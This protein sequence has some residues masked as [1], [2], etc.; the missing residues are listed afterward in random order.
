VGTSQLTE[1]DQVLLRPRLTGVGFDVFYR[2]A[3]VAARL[4]GRGIEQGEVFVAR[5]H[6]TDAA[7]HRVAFARAVAGDVASPAR[8]A[9]WALRVLA[10]ETRNEARRAAA[11]FVAEAERSALVEPVTRAEAGLARA[12]GSG[13][14]VRVALAPD[15]HALTAAA[16]A[17]E[18]AFA[19]LVDRLAAPG[20]RTAMRSDADEVVAAARAAPQALL[21]RLRGEWPRLVRTVGDDAPLPLTADGGGTG[22]AVTVAGRVT[23][24]LR[25]AAGCVSA[26]DC[27]TPSDSH[28]TAMRTRSP[29]RTWSA[30]A[31]R[32]RA[33]P[34]LMLVVSPAPK[35]TSPRR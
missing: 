8:R 9:A 20:G 16:A 26:A 27:T 11:Q 7:A 1:G 33:P 2:P 13:P 31:T 35:R 22:S 14:S 18:A 30:P 4:L 34:A 12:L 21:T 24:R 23:Y 10:E 6:P 3:P 17:L 28:A 15:R 5:T 32:T 25:L 29:T 19:R